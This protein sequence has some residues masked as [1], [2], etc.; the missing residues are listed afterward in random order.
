MIG[1]PHTAL[2]DHTI[3]L[4]SRQ[5]QFLKKNNVKLIAPVKGNRIH[6]KH[7]YKDHDKSTAMACSNGQCGM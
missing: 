4:V 2:N 3:G 6:V 7:V 1:Y 5:A